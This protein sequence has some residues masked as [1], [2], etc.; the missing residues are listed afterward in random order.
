M[1]RAGGWQVTIYK[2]QGGFGSMN[3]HVAFNWIVETEDADDMHLGPHLFSKIVAQMAPQIYGKLV[4]I[5]LEKF[6]EY[7]GPGVETRTQ[8]A[9]GATIFATCSVMFFLHRMIMR[10]LIR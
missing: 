9:V 3:L 2:C 6:P 7:P 4:C 5:M 8:F 1:T 10:W